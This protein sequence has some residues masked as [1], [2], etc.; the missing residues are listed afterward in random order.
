MPFG[1][2][3]EGVGVPLAGQMPGCPYDTVAKHLMPCGALKQ[4]IW[5]RQRLARSLPVAKHL[6]PFG[7]LKPVQVLRSLVLLVRRKEPNAL[8]GTA[9]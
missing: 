5:A 1:A 2:L 9:T 3:K 4:W 7:A 6:M 8:W